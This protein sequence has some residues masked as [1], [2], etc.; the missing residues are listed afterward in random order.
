MAVRTVA[1]SGAATAA[2]GGRHFCSNWQGEALTSV[3]QQQLDVDARRPL[4]LV[5]LIGEA[6]R[7]PGGQF[8]R[9]SILDEDAANV[10][11]QKHAL[12]TV[13]E[14]IRQVAATRGWRSRLVLDVVV[15]GI[16]N[17]S[18][19]ELAR[20]TTR[21]II[22][23]LVPYAVHVSDSRPYL[24]VPMAWAAALERFGTGPTWEAILLSRIDL[25][26]KM[27][28][29]LPAAHETRDRILMP[30]SI[31]HAACKKRQP[32]VHPRV[33]DTLVF[34]PRTV[35]D[36]F[37]D[38]L[39]NHSG[40]ADNSSLDCRDAHMTAA[41]M[42]GR[43][44]FLL[45]SQHDSNSQLQ[46]NPLYRIINRPE[47]SQAGLSCLTWCHT[48]KEEDRLLKKCTRGC[49][50]SHAACGH[51]FSS[52]AALASTPWEYARKPS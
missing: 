8:T 44:G 18:M 22:C 12:M 36:A 50:D 15:H 52:G 48:Q 38:V 45:A 11:E 39:R 1:T 43:L 27:D 9:T 26:F 19:A 23:P 20:R 47:A 6:F 37:V 41:W 35:R 16:R 49:F 14:H 33:A 29:P 32:A 3:Q 10:L 51:K 21:N 31:C 28:L 34:V 7:G 5:V 25:H 13:H 24:T 46:W 4:L 42:H 2:S 30:F 40:G 17:V